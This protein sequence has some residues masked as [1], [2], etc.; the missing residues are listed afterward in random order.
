M[1]FSTVVIGTTQ[2][3]MQVKSAANEPIAELQ[4]VF[5]HDTLTIPPMTT[6]T[7]TAF[8]NQAS[9]S[10][11]TCTVTPVGKITEA[12]SLLIFHSMPTLFDRK[13]AVR[14]TSPTDSPF[15]IKKKTQP[16]DISVFTPDQSKC[17][18]PLGTAS[19][20]MI[21]ESYPDLTTIT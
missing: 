8:V 12:A 4:P 6:N 1:I 7:I 19:F 10:N 3:T 17:I 21:P 11:T 16:A 15:S 13:M 14:V 20:K 5:F 18:K 2:L 9:E